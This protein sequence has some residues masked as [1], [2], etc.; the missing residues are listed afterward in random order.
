MI[1]G[2]VTLS[3]EPT[4][5]IPVAGLMMKAVIDTGFNGGLQLPYAV[6]APLNPRFA[7]RVVSVL[8][9]GQAVFEDIYNLQFLFDGRVVPT[10]ATFVQDTVILIGT[11]LLRHHRLDINFKARTVLIERVP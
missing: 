9:A 5:E 10:D 4:I 1:T 2:T 11:S 6:F 7:G 3:G 8:A